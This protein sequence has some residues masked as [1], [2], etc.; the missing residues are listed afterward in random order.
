MFRVIIKTNAMLG[1]SLAF[2]IGML[3]SNLLAQSPQSMPLSTG[4]CMVLQPQNNESGE[5]TIAVR[6]P[7]LV[8][9]SDEAAMLAQSF[10][11][12]PCSDT[13]ATT[14]D[15]LQWRDFICTTTATQN[16][17]VQRQLVDLLGERPA[18]LCGMAEAVL[19]PWQRE[20][21]N[22]ETPQPQLGG[23]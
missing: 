7:V 10:V 13:F 4:I 23:G 22:S 6:Q 20:T 8:P 9:L 5:A 18:V 2:L 15:Q 17:D 11:A 21:S 3:P 19:G 12:V 14:T 1:C 16:E